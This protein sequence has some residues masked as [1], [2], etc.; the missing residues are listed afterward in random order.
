MSWV[1]DY[2]SAM[3]DAGDAGSSGDGDGCLPY[4]ILAMPILTGIYIV[5]AIISFIL[6]AVLGLFGVEFDLI[7]WLGEF[8]GSLTN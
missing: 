3:I 5:V 4:L 6:K 7:L 2:D 1:D 8:L